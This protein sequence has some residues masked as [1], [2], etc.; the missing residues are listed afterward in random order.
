M[1]AQALRKLGTAQH[2]HVGLHLGAH[3]GRVGFVV[4][5]AHLAQV[6]AGLQHGQDDLAAAG[7]GGHHPGA[8]GEKDEQRVG[9]PALLHDDLATPEAP[10]DHPVGNG[11]RLVV[12]QHRK[13]RHPADQIQVR[14]HCHRC[15]QFRAAAPRC[16]ASS[17]ISV[18]PWVTQPRLSERLL[19][20]WASSPSGSLQC[21]DP[22][23]S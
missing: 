11:L 23:E 12:G 14:K 13:Q 3:G 9:L 4:D 2:Q 19:C 18:T 1:M 7:V 22:S 10:L 6:V 16:R 20:S 17:L 21:L 8:P 15:L 5:Q